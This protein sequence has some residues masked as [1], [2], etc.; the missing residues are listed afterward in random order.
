MS[1]KSSLYR[2][3]DILKR[4]NDGQRL[5]V[6][7]LALEYDVSDR[8]I[9]RDFV[10][11]KEIFGDFV[12]KD[13]ECY[14]AFKK[15]LLDKVLGS[16]DLMTLSNIVNLFAITQKQSSISD[17]TK[18]L[19]KKSMQVYDFKSRPFENMQY[20]EIL[21]T[22]EH[23]IAF[24]KEVKIGYKTKD[25]TF[26]AKLQPYKI[27]FLNEN[28]YLVGM[29]ARKYK[30]EFRRV[31]MITDV[32]LTG[33]TFF[34]DSEVVNFIKNIQTPWANFKSQTIEVRLK[35][36][37]KIARYFK[38][39]KYLPS[40]EVVDEFEDGS[41]EVLYR[42]S[43]LRELEELIIKWLP[44]IEIISPNNLKKMIKKVLHKKL[45]GL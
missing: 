40:Q 33:K 43:N 28:F 41:I 34:L 16:T 11:I 22:L 31:T 17:E 19:I 25:K 24:N 23:A 2:T 32:K 9:R 42:V 7:N 18:E 3:I 14:K 4:L 45:N 39:K 26:Y 37:Q 38:K 8:T 20:S 35:A 29:Y 1:Q 6:S 15:V 12:A 44:Q 27:L 13:G 21:K 5:C 36:S 30:F 10:L